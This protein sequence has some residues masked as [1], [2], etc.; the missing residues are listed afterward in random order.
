M[1]TSRNDIASDTT[2][3]ISLAC[4]WGLYGVSVL[5][6]GATVRRLTSSRA[7]RVGRRMIALATVFF[8]LSTAHAIANLIRLNEG[9]VNKRDSSFPNGSGPTAFFSDASQTY[10]VAINDIYSIQTLL[11]DAVV[12]YRCYVVWQTVKAILFPVTLWLG[13]LS[14]VIGCLYQLH[15]PNQPGKEI[16]SISDWVNAFFAMSLFT[17]LISTSLLAFKI[18]TV[19]KE[20]SKYRTTPGVLGPILRVIIDSGILYSVTLILTLITFISRS[21]SQ[22]IFL[23]LLM[24]VMAISFYLVIIRISMARRDCSNSRDVIESKPPSRIDCQLRPVEV[25]IPQLTEHDVVETTDE[26]NGTALKSGHTPD[27]L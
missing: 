21:N 15:G 4:E 13:L 3:I 2:A 5:L 8:A 19:N 20:A 9:F 23:D 24:P 26:V 10:F 11:A 18:W 27:P 14:T 7:P 22:F 16:F 17:N 12:V 1:A 6:Y 25:N